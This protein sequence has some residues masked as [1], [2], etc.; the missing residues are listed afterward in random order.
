MKRLQLVFTALLI[1]IDLLGI[2]IATSIASNLR[3]VL[4]ILPLGESRSITIGFSFLWWYVPLLILFMSIN[5]LYL[6]ADLRH[7]VSQLFRIISA[8]AAASMIL[9]MAVLV[10]RT[11][12]VLLRVP[13]W[14][15]WADNTSLLTVFY[16]W[17]STMVVLTIFR[18][19]YRSIVHTL[20]SQGVGSLRV[21][22]VGNT[23]VTKTLIQAISGD[24][25]LGYELIGVVHT[26][27]D[28]SSEKHLGDLDDL[29]AIVMRLKPDHIITADPELSYEKVLTIIDIANDHHI[30]FTFA[31]NLFEVLATNVTVTNIGG[32][33]LL[34]LRRTPL[35]GWGKILKRA[36]DV[37]LSLLLI[38]MLSP[39]LL[40]TAV[41]VKLQDYGP[42][43]YHQER[44]SLGKPF[45]II[46]YRSMIR[47]AERLEDSLRN[48]TNERAD[49]PLFKMKND[50]RV[51]ALGKFLRKSRLDELPQLFN[52]LAGDMSLI[53]PRP[54]LAKEIAL[55]QK[56]HRKV[57][58]I[59]PGMTGLAQLSGSSD[60]TFDEEVRLDTYYIENWSLARD[61]EILLK[62]PFII[63]FK[64]RS[65]V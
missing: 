7:R 17:L 20:Y 49:G 22:L 36:V 12:F 13:G 62:T 32:I 42:V 38:I 39:V 64:D 35:D 57:L 58:V 52:V 18:W 45:Q 2:V 34:N 23:D 50:P 43:F 25:S 8:S 27:A 6:L 55:Y 5:R 26:G 40:L 46:K 61:L 56:H 29:E 28:Q 65:G 9:F 53:G 60:L 1:P 16:L 63:V 33:P 51:T 47:D 4:D 48:R 44:M 54:H 59:K 30:E 24:H 31:P 3:T 14:N 37:G 21:L 10:G 19:V 41:C 11:S 15:N